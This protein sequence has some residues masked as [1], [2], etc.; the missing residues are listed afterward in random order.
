MANNSSI[1]YASYQQQYNGNDFAPNDLVSIILFFS[2]IFLLLLSF[3]FYFWFTEWH[4]VPLQQRHEEELERQKEVDQ[5]VENLKDQVKAAFKIPFLGLLVVVWK[6]SFFTTFPHHYSSNNNNNK[7]NII[8][9]NTSSLSILPTNS[10]HQE[11]FHPSLSSYLGRPQP[12]LI[13]REHYKV[14]AHRFHHSF[15]ILF[16]LGILISLV[17]LIATVSN[18]VITHTTSAT[19]QAGLFVFVLCINLFLITR[20]RFYYRERKQLFGDNDAHMNAIYKTQ[21]EDWDKSMWSNWVQIAILIIEFFQLLT[22]PLRDLITVNSFDNSSTSSQFSRFASLVLNA[23][24][25]M[26]DMRTPVWYTYTVWSAF[27][28]TVISVSVAVLVHTV[29]LYHPYKIPNRW[30]RWCISVATLL[31]IPVLTTFVSSAACQSLNV[32]TNDY[33]TTLRCHAPNISQQ[34]YLWLSLLG[35]VIAYFMMTMFLTSY[36]RIPVY[37]EIAFKSISVAFIKNMGKN[38]KVHFPV[39]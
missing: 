27:V 28:I 1:G 11:S 20:Q 34:L 5:L 36:E 24:G 16:L 8:L 12:I 26:P 30:V 19:L 7:E 35:Y 21:F 32:S 29:N 37:N 25:L 18:R 4:K 33:A 38:D 31:Y 17:L 9:S 14:W 3:V 10:L 6:G 22:F 13:S 39:D 15:S 2:I 23:G